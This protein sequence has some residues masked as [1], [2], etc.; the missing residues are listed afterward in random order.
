MLNVSVGEWIDSAELV[1]LNFFISPLAQKGQNAFPKVGR[2]SDSQ[3]TDMKYGCAINSN[4]NPPFSGSLNALY[5]E[6]LI[7]V[8]R[9]L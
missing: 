2:R 5:I 1:K 6:I 7:R 8:K 3:L 9:L 4:L